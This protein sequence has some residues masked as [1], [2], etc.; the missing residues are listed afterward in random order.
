MSL[1]Q[2]NY[3]LH[4]NGD[5]VIKF[6]PYQKAQSALGSGVFDLQTLSSWY[7]EDPEKNHLGLMES[8]GTRQ[9]QQY[10]IF[11][12]LLRDRKVIEVGRDGRFTYDV[13]VYEDQECMTTEDMSHQ[14]NAGVDG[15]PF[16]VVLSEEFKPGDVLTYD[17]LYGEQFVVTEEEVH[18]TGT[19]FEHIV[20][21]VS[22]DSYDYFPASQLAAGISYA[23][24]NHAMFGEYGTNY[25]AA[26]LPA[27]GGGT[28]RVEF[29]LGS[30][31]GV[32]LFLTGKADQQFSGAAA[33]ADTLKYLG[34]LDDHIEKLGG[35]VAMVFDFDKTTQKV[36]AKSAKLASTV[37]LLVDKELDRLT[38]SALMFQKAG[39]VDSSHGSATFNEG[40]WHQ[41]RRGKIIKYPRPMGMTRVHVGEAT[42]YI[43]R[44][45]P[46][47][48]EERELTFEAGT[49]M[50][51]NFMELFSDEFQ[52][53]YAS[54]GGL[55]MFGSDSQLPSSPISGDLM[56]LEIKPMRFTKVF[57][58]RIG[59]VR[60]K[61]NTSLDYL[62]KM[63]RFSQ[64]MHPY[65]KSH[66]AYSA[67]IF[68][69]GSKEYSNNYKMPEGAKLIEGGQEGSGVYLVKPRGNFKYSGYEQGRYSSH[70][71]SDIMSSVK[72][73]STTYWAWNQISAWASP[74]AIARTV[75]IELDPANRKGYI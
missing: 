54:L 49:Y 23:K 75:I 38:A 1:T 14:A 27:G 6:M 58:A 4:V 3:P 63:D 32:E 19:G 11:P 25:S 71:A 26:H 57:L 72:T 24:I 73:R 62:A 55:G 20:K 5:K 10:G 65:Q 2:T 74:N 50:Y 30:E 15:S 60:V 68:D 7:E 41:F 67:F 39:R 52:A 45:N 51:E 44:G 35:E 36:N 37:Q 29:E 40:L 33:S 53:Q 17:A 59:N 18:M 61:K 8:W 22:N 12:D 16:K 64:G 31:R 13:P 70:K 43:Y 69:A 48:P 47:S 46:I 9:M 56:N 42:E 21:I 34:D 28:M 66:T